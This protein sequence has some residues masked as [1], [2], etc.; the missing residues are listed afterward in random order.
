MNARKQ[1]QKENK[2][3]M[4]A[5]QAVSGLRLK[6]VPFRGPDDPMQPAPRRR[7]APSVNTFWRG[8]LHICDPRWRGGGPAAGARADIATR[9]HLGR[10]PRE[11]VGPP[12]SPEA[13]SSGDSGAG[14]A[15]D[16]APRGVGRGGVF[17]SWRSGL[18]LSP[19]VG[20]W[21]RRFQ[22]KPAAARPRWAPPPSPRP[23]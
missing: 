8:D 6:K 11:G 21:T 13:Q 10:A 16:H 7:R 3:T 4:F 23:R 22:C 14:P 15:V 9:R 17:K 18:L 19:G 20:L 1:Q 2:G 5:G 12:R